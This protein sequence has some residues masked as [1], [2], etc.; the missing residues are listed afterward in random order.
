M[1]D[2]PYHE[3]KS[4][5]R[6]AKVLLAFTRSEEWS[7]SDLSKDLRLHKSVVHRLVMTLADSALLLRD[8]RSGNYRLGP[9]MADL[10][11]RAERDNLLHRLARPHLEKLARLSGETA[12]LQVVQGDHGLCVDVVESPDPMRLTISPGQS[13]PLHAGCAGKIILAFRDGDFIERQ[14]SKKPLQRYTESTI[15]DPEA[16]RMELSS[17]RERGIGFSDSEITPG[18]RSIGVPVRGTNGSVVASLVVSGP[19]ERMTDQ[20]IE[21]LEKPMLSA[22]SELSTSLGFSGRKERSLTDAV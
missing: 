10:G 14:I 12:S 17:I 22:A 1:S 19:S 2:R 13:F 6:A 8:P 4:V 9:M 7:L 20:H 11:A 5:A 21:S 3:L 15:T 18:A 16:L